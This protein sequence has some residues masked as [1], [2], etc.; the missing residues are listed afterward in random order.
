[1]EIVTVSP[2]YGVVIPRSICEK[3]GINPGQRL[4]VTAADRRVELV[5]V[6]AARGVRGLLR[7][8]ETDLVRE[9]DR[10]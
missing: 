7:G 5:P 6:R 8:I 10:L 9:P 1:M 2:E 3:L 4:L